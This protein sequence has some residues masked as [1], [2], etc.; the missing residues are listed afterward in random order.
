MRSSLAL[1]SPNARGLQSPKPSSEVFSANAV[2]PHSV[3][4]LLALLPLAVPLFSCQLLKL[5]IVLSRPQDARLESS[6]SAGMLFVARQ[7][8][9]QSCRSS[10]LSLSCPLCCLRPMMVGTIAR[11]R[12][13]VSL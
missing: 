11:T 6:Q 9:V 7:Y 2:A 1:Y 12:P 8:A 10:A 3:L 4:A 5:T 13:Y